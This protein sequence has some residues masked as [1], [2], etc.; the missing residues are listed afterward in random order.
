MSQYYS[1]L[2]KRLEQSNVINESEITEIEDSQ[3]RRDIDK[4]RN[5]WKSVKEVQISS[6]Q[7]DKAPTIEQSRF[8]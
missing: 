7:F 5:L 8:R 6:I 3:L 2:K 1:N 4:L